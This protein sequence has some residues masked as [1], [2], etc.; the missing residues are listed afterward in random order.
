MIT[1]KVEWFRGYRI[2]M[3]FFH[4]QLMK[5]ATSTVLPSLEMY[6]R[7]ID[8]KRIWDELWNLVPLAGDTCSKNVYDA[9]GNLSQ[10][11]NIDI[12]LMKSNAADGC[13]STVNVRSSLLSL[14][15]CPI[16]IVV[17]FQ[18]SS[19]VGL[20]VLLKDGSPQLISYYY[21][22]HSTMLT[23][24]HSLTHWTSLLS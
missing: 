22:I 17:Y 5:L 14:S 23:M 2:R 21:T 7:C 20:V 24:R 8:E 15:T 19:N 12:K 10:E 1:S 13:P 4:W 3:F 11:L 18:I 9:L 6:V 16:Y